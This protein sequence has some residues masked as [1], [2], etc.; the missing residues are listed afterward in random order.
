M[1]LVHNLHRFKILFEKKKYDFN[2]SS[3]T[4][5]DFSN[6]NNPFC[7]EDFYKSSSQLF[8]YF[9]FPIKKS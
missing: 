4:K 5:E 2:F 6:D 1:E 9:F 8:K 3:E 7:S